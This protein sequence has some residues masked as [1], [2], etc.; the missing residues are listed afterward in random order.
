MIK[1]WGG[2]G[3]RSD[4]WPPLSRI[5]AVIDSIF[6]PAA[7]PNTVSWRTVGERSPAHLTNG[8]GIHELT[9]AR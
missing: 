8:A 2:S 6:L 9:A 4:R 5:R 1:Q 3:R 7:F